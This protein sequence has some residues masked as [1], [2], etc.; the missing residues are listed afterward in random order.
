MVLWELMC[1]QL[2]QSQQTS[3]KQH[4]QL[5]QMLLARRMVVQVVMQL[6]C[7]STST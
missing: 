2:L 5:A 1:V 4:W 7:S 3:L 6:S